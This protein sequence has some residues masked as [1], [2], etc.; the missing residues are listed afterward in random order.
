MYYD[1]VKKE[2]R[3]TKER[4]GFRFGHLGIIIYEK[5][6]EIEKTRLDRLTEIGK[7]IGMKISCSA[8]EKLPERLS[9]GKQLLRIE[10]L[11]LKNR[12]QYVLIKMK[13]KKLFILSD[14]ELEILQTIFNFFLEKGKWPFVREIVSL[15]GN[16]AVDDISRLV[17][18]FPK[19]S[20]LVHEFDQD[21]GKEMYR[22]TLFGILHLEGSE[23]FFSEISEIAKVLK[24]AIKN[25][26]IS[27]IR[28][29][30]KKIDLVNDVQQREVISMYHELWSNPIHMI[31][32][33]NHLF[34]HVPEDADG[35]SFVQSFHDPIS[36]C[37]LRS[38]GMKK[39]M[40]DEDR[41]YLEKSTIL[42]HTEANQ[43]NESHALII[44]IE[45]YA[46]VSI[47]DV[48]YAAND[49]NEF[50]SAIVPL[51]YPECSQ[52][53]LINNQATQAVIK[54][55]LNV[56]TQKCA[57]GDRLLVFYAG[58]GFSKDNNNYITCY[59]TLRD[60]L[61]GTSITLN[62]IFEVLREC[63]CEKVLLFLD[64][65]HS[66]LP[67]DD[68]MRD[69]IG[70]MS[71]DELKAFLDEAEF[72]CGFASCKT[73]QVSYHS[74]ELKHGIWSFHLIKALKGN[75]E[76]AMYKN[77]V[78][79]SMS[80]QNYLAKEVP[81]TVQNLIG[82]TY[83]QVPVV[84]G[85]QTHEFLVADLAPVR[86][87]DTVDYHDSQKWNNKIQRSLIREKK[88][89]LQLENISGHD[90]IWKNFGISSPDELRNLANDLT[91]RKEVPECVRKEFERIRNL[92]IHSYSQ[93]DFLDSAH[94]KALFTFEMALKK[95]YQELENK[96]CRLKLPKLITWAVKNELFEEDEHQIRSLK[97]LRDKSAHP[98]EWT[99]LGHLSLFAILKIRNIING[100][101]ENTKLRRE[102]KEEFA[103]L[104]RI[105]IDFNKNG[106]M[107]EINSKRRV[108]FLSQL[109]FY[110]N[111]HSPAIYYFLFYPIFDLTISEDKSVDVPSPLIFKTKGYSRK[112]N[113]ICLFGFLK[114]EKVILS[115]I[116]KFQDK[117]RFNKW[118][119]QFKKH[120]FPLKN[121]IQ[122]R[123]VKIK[124]Y[125][126]DKAFKNSIVSSKENQ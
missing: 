121:E 95:R 103:R 27:S 88:I 23:P 40:D 32:Y 78:I 107:L 114:D 59:D 66:G 97:N 6:I 42:E 18:S 75:A 115:L 49:A 61:V 87:H 111:V 77:F 122:Y 117:E 74:D 50:L 82:S 102:R 109:V 73:N 11:P 39:E 98:E 17:K 30:F 93:Y 72:R 58:H 120:K 41:Q 112:T 53:V 90:P 45:K 55:R 124:N 89:N 12:E 43:H 100:L 7:S 106:V 80:L 19:D 126:Q 57:S 62:K 38:M 31:P 94:D 51:D 37:H 5:F 33:D 96:K 3:K 20:I 123:I 28:Y 104:N 21:V 91:F 65:C 35:I 54:S 46:D 108:I 67:I 56:I 44:A 15:S 86:A 84:F 26:A 25:P 60:D 99:L 105:F 125:L 2:I 10:N 13:V 47:Q 14:N 110:D 36:F 92:I 116:E 16:S 113:Q 118:I 71:S 64:C 24:E 34:I 68:R 22:L 119:E 79:T 63:K 85:N 70:S 52:I 4:D 48:K 8:E 101:Y 1:E 81:K 69:I 83:I 9:A 29:Y 76:E